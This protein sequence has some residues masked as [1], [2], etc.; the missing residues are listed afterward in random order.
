MPTE[1]VPSEDPSESLSLEGGA[2]FFDAGSTL[3]P[4]SAGLLH[5]LKIVKI[6]KDCSHN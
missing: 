5:P 2:T 1:K 4:H 6:L 3:S